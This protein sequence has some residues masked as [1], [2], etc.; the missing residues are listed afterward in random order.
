MKSIRHQ[1]VTFTLLLVVLPFI[2]SGIANSFSMNQSYGKKLESDNKMLAGVVA[3]QVTAFIEKGYSITEQITLNS[4]V[5]ALVPDAQKQ[6]LLDVIDKHPY[7]DLLYIQGTDG[8]QTARSK[9]ELGDRSNRWW[10]IKVKDEKQA[11]VSKSYFSLTGNVPVTTIAMPIYDK[12]EVFAGVMGADIKLDFLQG[13]IEK[14]SEGSKYAFLLD[15]EGVIIAHP[16]KLQVSELYNYKTVKKTVLKKDV[17]GNIIKDESGNQVT[18]E[19]DIVIPETLKVI[20]EK[21]LAGESGS[22]TYKNNEGIEVISA[23]Q[24]I[25]LPGSSDK[26]A[27]V[28]VENKADAMT[29]IKN[30]EYYNLIIGLGAI[31]IASVLVS[32]SSRRITHP[33]KRSSEYLKQIAQGNFLVEVDP[34]LLGRKDEIGVIANGIQDMKE[35]LKHL[36]LSIK[37]ESDNIENK[38]AD[39]MN[40]MQI[41]N[42]NFESVSA[43]TEELAAGMEET[44]AM[45]HAMTVTSQEIEKAVHSIAERSQ[46]GAVAAREISVR[47]EQTQMN[48]NIAQKKAFEV[49]VNTRE[50]LEKAIEASQV[51]DQI[52]LLSEAIMQ[53]TDQTNLLALNAAIE[54]ARA[55]EAGKGFAVVADEIR[56]LAEQS[57]ITVMKIQEVTVKVTTS[58]ENLSSSSNNLLVFMNTEV[59]DDYRTMLEV[60]DR[61]RGD[62]SFVD[63]LVTEF[64]ATSEELL[65]S[66]ENILEAIDGVANSANESAEG[67]TDI[68]CRVV[69]VN[70]KSSEVMEEVIKSKES[71]ERLKSEIIKFKF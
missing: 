17:D 34:K 25:S 67:T 44:A 41:L 16:D 32:L 8:M 37:N 47:A 30:L 40:N 56:K 21:A 14:Y 68:A 62:A 52:H 22:A 66:I 45:S 65:A 63:Q 13:T 54:A 36:V 9:G 3:D 1:L 19:L 59:N 35:A 7:F 12:N 20:T 61:Y 4:D 57:K 69:E 33:I 70:L 43:T 64:S 2:I 28:T 42:S 15:G 10:F 11:F 58:V 48:V 51:V 38:V 71:A 39:A 23:Y 53:I 49:F 29:F 5:K 26:W 31:I 24:S 46:E 27:V 18:E 55:G 6:V 50:Q 60:A